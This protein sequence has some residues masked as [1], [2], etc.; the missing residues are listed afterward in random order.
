MPYSLLICILRSDF[1][2]SRKVVLET[3]IL[4]SGWRPR[5]N[6]ALYYKQAFFQ[7]AEP[8]FCHPQNHF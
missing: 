1:K 8:L 6:L 3:Q 7:V 2:G 4:F 5:K